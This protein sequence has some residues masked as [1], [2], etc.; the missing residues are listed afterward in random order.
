VTGLR[1]VASAE[2]VVLA[3]EK[4]GKQKT[5][6]QIVCMLYFLFSLASMEPTFC[7]MR[8]LYNWKP[9]GITIA[10]VILVW[11]ALILTLA[12]GL[13]YVWKNRDLL[14]DC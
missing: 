11:I 12:S 10:G 9:T 4:L 8:W 3:A 1:L 2:G 14:K 7:W 5:I 6:W 13:S